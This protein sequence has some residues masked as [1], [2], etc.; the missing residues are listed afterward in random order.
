[1]VGTETSSNDSMDFQEPIPPPDATVEP[2]LMLMVAPIYSRIPRTYG[3]DYMGVS[4]VMVVHQVRWMV[5]FM[6]NTNG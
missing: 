6:E 3:D 2:W 5:Y 1:M 4:M